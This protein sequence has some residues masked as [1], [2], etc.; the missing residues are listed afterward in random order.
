MRARLLATIEEVA[1]GGFWAIN[2]CPVVDVEVV[3]SETV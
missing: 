1:V 2:V 3:W